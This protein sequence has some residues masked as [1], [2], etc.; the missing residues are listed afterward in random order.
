MVSRLSRI[1]PELTLQNIIPMNS[2]VIVHWAPVNSKSPFGLFFQEAAATHFVD[3]SGML[4]DLIPLVT[5]KTEEGILQEGISGKGNRFLCV[6]R[7]RRFGKTVM[8]SMVASFFSRAKSSEE[9]F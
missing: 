2:K 8:A 3:K 9:L 4:R 5:P 7:P 1:F 6:T